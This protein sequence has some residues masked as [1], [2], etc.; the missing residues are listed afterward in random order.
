MSVYPSGSSAKAQVTGWILNGVRLLGAQPDCVSV[1]CIGEAEVPLSSLRRN[2]GLGS[3]HQ[4]DACEAGLVCILSVC[5]DRACSRNTWMK[6][7]SH[8]DPHLYDNSFCPSWRL[9]CST[10]VHARP[11]TPRCTKQSP[12]GWRGLVPFRLGWSCMQCPCGWKCPYTSPNA[13][14]IRL[15]VTLF[16]SA[17]TLRH[18]WHCVT[19]TLNGRRSPACLSLAVGAGGR[20]WPR[21]L[22]WP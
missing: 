11:P 21:G 15:G 5:I 10:F 16:H 1:G 13:C 19:H 20:W 2:S 7:W 8:Y 17:T 6:G 3:M 18:Q 14:V 4:T 22:S 12:K 9:W